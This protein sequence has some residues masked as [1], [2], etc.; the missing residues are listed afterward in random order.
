MYTKEQIQKALDYYQTCHSQT[1]TI[2]ALGYPHRH[3]LQK[4]LLNNGERKQRKPPRVDYSETHPRYPSTSF[5]ISAVHRCIHSNDKVKLV[6]EQIG[7]DITTLQRWIRMYKKEG[8]TAF[9]RKTKKKKVDNAINQDLTKKELR[10]Q[11]AELQLENDI[12]RQTID[13]LKK[14][15]GVDTRA[16]KNKEKAAI[17]DAL[18]NKYSL[19]TLLNK[20][21]FAKS[22][23]HYHKDVKRKPDKYQYIRKDIIDIFNANRQCYGYRRIHAQ[24]KKRGYTISEKVVRRIM[25]EEGLKVRTTKRKTYTSYVGEITPAV[26]NIINRDFSAEKPNEKWLTDITE[27]AIPAGKI[28]LSPIVDCFDGMIPAWN[29]GISPNAELVNKMLDDAIN[30][31][32]QDEHP[33]IHSDRGGHY[34]WP[35]WI[36][37][38]NNANLI[39]S[40][41]KKG[42][43]PDNSACEGF[44]GRLKNEMFYGRNWQK[45]TIPEFI[46]ELNSYIKWY[47][48]KRIKKSLNYKSPFEYRRSLGL[49]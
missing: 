36:K 19:Q 29:I 14:D 42:C 12:L 1:Q 28:Y 10:K 13:V 41:S 21:D 27:F 7:Y 32:A 4:W 49:I 46:K 37:K 5:K 17:V 34:R 22:G 24:L 40:M 18:I 15:P 39:R 31:L 2:L 47:N 25:R 16:L 35:K 48:T 43:S 33:I 9:M 23:Y 26:P 30:L 45:T 20:L 8:P 38:M 44:F 3:T 11:L 6:A